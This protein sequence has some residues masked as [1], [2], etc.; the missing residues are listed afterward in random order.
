MHVNKRGETTGGGKMPQKEA[1]HIIW[2]HLPSSHQPAASDIDSGYQ[3][4]VERNL[5][6]TVICGS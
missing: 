6:L 4:T 1:L 5:F 3:R 2:G